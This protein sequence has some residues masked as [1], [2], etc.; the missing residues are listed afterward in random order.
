MKKKNNTANLLALSLLGI[1]LVLFILFIK[2]QTS[3]YSSINYE[4]KNQKKNTIVPTPFYYNLNDRKVFTI[5]NARRTSNGLNELTWSDTL[6][7]SAKAKAKDMCEKQYWAH[8]SPEGE[9]PWDFIKGKI[10]YDTAGENLGK[11]F[12]NE[13]VLVNS[14]MASTTHKENILNNTYTLSAVAVYKCKFNGIDTQLVVQH[15]MSPFTNSV[16][17]TAVDPNTPIHCNISE[18]CGGGT[19]PLKQWECENS[20]CC[21]MKDGSWKFYVNKEQCISDQKAG[22]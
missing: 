3:N 12:E 18:N 15:F 22:L 17:N 21:Q 10:N 11:D 5:V 6:F 8:T 1:M 14:W 19:T 13:T 7:E 2:W 9:T 4:Y 20:T 16:Q